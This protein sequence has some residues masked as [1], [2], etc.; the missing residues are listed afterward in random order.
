MGHAFLG[1]VPL[2]I[3]IRIASD[4]GEPPA[5]GEGPVAASFNAIAGRLAAWLDI[6][7]AL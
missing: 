7:A 2:D 4:A 6:N 1:R 5:A 3:A